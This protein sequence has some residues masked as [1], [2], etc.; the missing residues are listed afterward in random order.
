MLMDKENKPITLLNWYKLPDISGLESDS[1]YQVQILKDLLK[2][3]DDD[4]YRQKGAFGTTHTTFIKAIIAE[5]GLRNG[6]WVYANKM[7]GYA[8]KFDNMQKDLPNKFK[9]RE[10]LYDLH[11][12]KDS[13]DGHYYMPVNF[14][15]AMECEWRK[16]RPGDTSMK[17]FSAVKYDFQKL[18][19]TNAPLKLLIFK[20]PDVNSPEFMKLDNYFDKAITRYPHLCKG[21][22]F[23]IICFSKRN[24]FYTEK[25]KKCDAVH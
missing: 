23:L 12:Y 24:I 15:L 3:V 1:I 5:T 20:V 10:W 14:E 18:L 13:V 16:S 4:F 2:G 8:E 7:P 17:N 25:I 6:Y 9:E 19:V 11:W 21:S 22:K